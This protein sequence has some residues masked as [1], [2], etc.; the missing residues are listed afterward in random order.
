[1]FPALNGTVGIETINPN[2]SGTAE[3]LTDTGALPAQARTIQIP[4]DSF[5]VAQ[6]S[7]GLLVETY[8]SAGSYPA[9]A[10]VRLSLFEAHHVAPLG[11]ASAIVAAQGH[12]VAEV[13]CP[14][15][16]STACPLR[17]IDTLTGRARSVQPPAGYEGYVPVAGAFSTNG[18]LLAGFVSSQ[19]RSGGLN[20]RLAVIA[21][22]TLVATVVG[23]SLPFVNG[24]T[25]VTPSHDNHWF[26]FSASGS[27]LYAEQA[28]NT[29]PRGDPWILPLPGSTL[30]TTM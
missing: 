23:P 20:V 29:G 1:V 19:D 17:L 14:P 24:S 25:K 18:N 11:D 15:N 13:D 27:S 4:A 22:N 26:F 9:G 10:Y 3:F 21:T 7:N 2:S 5:A 8:I 6:L 30:V 28:T 12:T 16:G